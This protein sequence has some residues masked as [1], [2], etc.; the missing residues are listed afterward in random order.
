MTRDQRIYRVTLMGSVV[1]FILLIIKFAAG[2]LGHSA[3]MIADAIHSLSDFLTDIV[4]I[5]FVRISSK[6]ADENHDYGHGKYETIATSVIGMVLLIVAITIGWNGI[7]KIVMFAQGD[8]IQSPE[9]IALVAAI[10]SISLKEWIF[11]MTRKVAIEIDSQALEAN[12]WHHRSDALSSIGTAIGIGGAVLLGNGWAI[13]DPIAA[14]IVS[15]LIIGTALRLLRQAS[16]ELLE[17]SLPKETVDRIMSIVYQDTLVSDIHN[18][19][20]RRIGSR[21]AI[22]M[23]LR[24]PGSITIEE[25]HIHA[26]AIER[27]LREEFGQSTHIM[28]HIEPVKKNRTI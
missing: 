17:E 18:L 25:A 14:V 11:R 16:G 15:I 3:A 9:L 26:S 13:L 7:E 1:N 5:I 8:E 19:H 22:E 2:I 21:I 10:A 12:A 6:P 24:L 20:T 27:K 28:L 23:H 4:V